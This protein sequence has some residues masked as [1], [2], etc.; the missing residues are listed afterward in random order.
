V[1]ELPLYRELPDAF[2][3][4]LSRVKIPL[5][6][7]RAAFDDPQVAA[8]V[9]RPLRDLCAGKLIVSI[10]AGIPLRRLCDWFGTDRVIRTM[11]NTPLMVGK[12]ATVMTCAA[13]A[14]PADRESVRR[15]FTS[16][17]IVHELP[18]E[19]IDAV[20]ALSGSGPAYVF[21]MIQ[22]LVDAGVAAG[23][24]PAVALD[25]MAQTVAGAAEMVQR[26][27]GTPDELRQAV[28]SP[29]GT[30]A[31]ALKVAADRHFRQLL[32]D[33]FTAARRRSEEL[34]RGM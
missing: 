9:V 6:H 3:E 34:G 27:L 8:E 30:T 14:T 23:L 28:T 13:G 16:V 2:L 17:G 12:G 24:P 25:L 33:M 10:A 31:A 29:A 11:P 20:T 18:E 4:T 1:E 15:I 7:H 21:E 32:G 19:L 22:G 26:R 5:L